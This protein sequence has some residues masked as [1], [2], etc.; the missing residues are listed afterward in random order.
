M[1]GQF[2]A[3]T[4]VSPAESKYCAGI[5][6]GHGSEAKDRYKSNLGVHAVCK[7]RPGGGHSLGSLAA[8]EL[9][10]LCSKMT[11]SCTCKAD[12]LLHVIH[13]LQ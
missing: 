2:V 9:L 12:D 11:S 7:P 5:Y 10:A 3:T 4:L 13:L 8:C 1:G 6:Y